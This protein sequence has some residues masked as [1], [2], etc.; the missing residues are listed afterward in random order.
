MVPGMKTAHCLLDP[1]SAGPSVVDALCKSPSAKL[2]RVTGTI[3]LNILSSVLSQGN[4]A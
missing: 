2:L 1:Y 3:D 4:V